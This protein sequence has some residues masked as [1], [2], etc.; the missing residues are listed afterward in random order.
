ME[1]ES[2]FPKYIIRIPKSLQKQGK[3]LKNNNKGS[4]DSVSR[5]RKGLHCTVPCQKRRSAHLSCSLGE[6]SHIALSKR[7]DTDADWFG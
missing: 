3:I 7:Q 2:R 4:S 6:D 5:S 1:Q